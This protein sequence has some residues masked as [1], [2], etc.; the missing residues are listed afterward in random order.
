MFSL[1]QQGKRKRAARVL[2][3]RYAVEKNEIV[4]AWP[5]L[6]KQSQFS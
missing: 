6:S 5:A 2:L 1:K 3:L 4:F